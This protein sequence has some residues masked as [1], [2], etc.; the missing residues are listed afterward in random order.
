MTD[1][2]KEQ[3]QKETEQI[4]APA[5]LIARTKAAMREEEM[6]MQRKRSRQMAELTGWEVKP[7]VQGPG[8]A[9]KKRDWNRTARRWAYPLTA[10]AVIFI[11]AS[12]SL[13]MR[14]LRNLESDSAPLY[15]A[16]TTA[17]SDGAEF[18]TQEAMEEAVCE[19]A[20]MLEDSAAAASGTGAESGAVTGRGAESAAAE[21]MEKA[22]A[23]D[24]GEPADAAS[25][26]EES[27]GASDMEAA[28][29]KRWQNQRMRQRKQ[30]RHPLRTMRR[31]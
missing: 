26:M 18:A 14:G 6:R 4:H 5:D 19:E 7:V 27:A 12:V 13:M 2:Y 29:E 10:V 8:F 31:R 25:D 1:Q 22:E 20:P 30:Q 16:V 28:S 11:L 17:D 23:A 9:E 3:Y 21:A 24:M 15:D